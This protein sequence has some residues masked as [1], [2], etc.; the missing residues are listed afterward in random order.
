MTDPANDPAVV[1]T[2]EYDP[3]GAARRRTVFRRAEGELEQYI[4]EEQ[5]RDHKNDWRAVGSERVLSVAIDTEA[6]TDV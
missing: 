5:V 4:R 6:G 2:V 1:A 3:A